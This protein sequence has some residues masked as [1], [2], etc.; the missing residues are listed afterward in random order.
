MAKPAPVA[1]AEPVVPVCSIFLNRGVAS[2]PRLTQIASED[3]TLRLRGCML[4]EEDSQF[5]TQASE[6]INALAA[7]PAYILHYDSDPKTAAAFIR[8]MLP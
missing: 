2:E 7:K 8:K 1:P 6:A 5:D 4:F 3:T